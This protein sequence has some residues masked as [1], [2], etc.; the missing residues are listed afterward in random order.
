MSQP[1][2][3]AAAKQPWARAVN[4]RSAPGAV[5]LGT[6]PAAAPR[7]LEART[8]SH[9]AHLAATFASATSAKVR[10]AQSRIESIGVE[11][12]QGE[13]HLAILYM[14]TFSAC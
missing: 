1:R 4:P 2:R 6:P 11:H 8:P 5:F 12:D 10:F 14:A 9:I 3:G 7:P 13:H